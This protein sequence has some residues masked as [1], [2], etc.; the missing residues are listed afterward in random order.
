MKRIVIRTLSGKGIGYGHYCRCLSL[1]KA[2]KLL[3]KDIDVIFIINEELVSL[4]K[5]TEFKS[6]IANDLV[7]DNE[8]IDRTNP[9]LFIFDSYLGSNEYLNS[10]KEKTKLMLIDDNNDIYDSTVP[11]IIYNGN[12]YADKL[13]YSKT[14]GQL[15]LLGSKYLIMREEYWNKQDYVALKDGILI[16]T[17]GTDEY[18]I[19]SKILKEIRDLDIKIKVIIGHGYRD[20]YIS[21]IEGLK[22]DSVELIYK[23][24]G[25]KDCILSS[26]VVVTAGGSTIYEILSQKCTPV[27]F[28]IA[29]N[30]DLA[31]QTLSKMGIEYIGKYPDIDYSKLGKIIEGLDNKIINKNDKIFNL[32]NGKGALLVAKALISYID[33]YY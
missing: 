19:T 1:A 9:T 30:Q 31:C 12:I 6:V 15:R 24:N 25:L 26:K 14:K 2:I 32:V 11:D 7:D 5:K 13:R 27:L 33:K 8:L 17:G 29:D 20:E 4:I 22:A 10:I 3:D 16:T 23:P 18:G 21:K 28:S